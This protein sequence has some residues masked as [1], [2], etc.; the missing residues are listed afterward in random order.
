MRYIPYKIDTDISSY[1]IFPRF[2]IPLDLSNDAKVI[3]PPVLVVRRI[4]RRT[5][6]NRVQKKGCCVSQ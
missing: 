3:V 4:S 6:C 5:C 1:I 2:L